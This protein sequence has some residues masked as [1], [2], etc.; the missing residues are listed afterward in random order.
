MVENG[1]RARLLHQDIRGI[2][3]RHRC[4]GFAAP[5]PERCHLP[6]TSD[7]HVRAHFMRAH[8]QTARA[9]PALCRECSADADLLSTAL[10]ACPLCRS[11]YVRKTLLAPSPSRTIKH[12]ARPKAAPMVRK[13]ECRSVARPVAVVLGRLPA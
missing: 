5:S 12:P 10:D 6:R 7:P 3:C 8:T 1:T 2:F 13:L 9:A 4:N 11:S